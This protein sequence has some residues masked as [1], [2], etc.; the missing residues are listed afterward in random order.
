MVYRILTINPG[1]TST[2]IALYEDLEEIITR[3]IEHKAGELEKFKQIA[4]Q[5]DL[6]FKYIM[7]FIEEEGIELN[8]LSVIVGRGGL[9]EPIS[10][11]TYRVNDK[12]KSH[13]KEGIQGE[14][15]SNLGGLL[16]SVL[17]EKAGCPAFIVDPVVVDEMDDVA[18]ISGIPD[19]KRRSIFHALNQKAVARKYAEESG[20][21]YQDLNIIV[22][23]LGGG[24]SVGLHRQGRVIDVNNALSGEG[25]FTPER[26]GGLPSM[27]LVN[28][29]F[30]GQYTQDEVKNK[31][32]GRGGVRAYLGTGD[33]LEVEKRADEGDKQA[34]LIF[35]AMAYQ[36]AREI[37]SLAPVV[38][39][40]VDAI[41][42]T[43]GI[44]HSDWLTFLIKEM[45]S[46]IAPV[47]IYPGEEEMKAL[48]AGAYRVLTGDEEVRTY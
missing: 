27:D 4:E 23:H 13:L 25:P 1:S 22:A 8:R 26:S 40:K 44:A 5:F 35:R 9:L 46:F 7:D 33:M 6:R 36:I 38:K 31:L 24:I 30:S 43:G 47:K 45:V 39:G 17:S 37:G 18:R 12:M 15:A 41:I 32:K 11:G 48:A 34:N 28:L 20:R 16:A 14:H 19:L 3:K 29:C 21:R 10:G 2:K 42:L